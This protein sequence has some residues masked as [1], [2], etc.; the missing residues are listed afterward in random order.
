MVG[1]IHGS[2]VRY[3]AGIAL[4]LFGIPS[5]SFAASLPA[6]RDVVVAPGSTVDVEI[7]ITNSGPADIDFSLLLLSASFQPGV[8]QPQL[9]QLSPAF[10]SWITLSSSSIFVPSGASLPV[11]LAVHP[12]E[13]AL[14]QTVTLAVVAA[15]KLDG[16]ISLIHG[17]A[18]L[19]FVSVGDVSPQGSCESFVQSPSG[20]GRV[21]LSNSGRGIL[22]DNGEII[23]RGM[24]GIRLGSTSSNPLF[25]RVPPGQTRTWQVSLPTIP[26]WAMGSFSY[27]LRDAQLSEHPC[28]DI[29]AGT[30]WLPLFG[31]G[32]AAFGVVTLCIRRRIS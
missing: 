20:E 17:S 13:N 30:R 18:A 8:E 29:D 10:T 16:D 7:P 1:N 24:F 3:A 2:I 11:M 23:L 19:V 9:E 6:T 22:Y 25:H 14:S 12:P 28:A 32:I 26:W 4:A 27:S 15:E 31:I 21:S 5:L